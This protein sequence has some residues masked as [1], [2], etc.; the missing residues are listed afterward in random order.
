MAKSGL[1]VG[2]TYKYAF[3]ITLYLYMYKIIGKL[4]NLGLYHALYVSSIPFSFAEL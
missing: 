3:I 2:H 1:H 4:N